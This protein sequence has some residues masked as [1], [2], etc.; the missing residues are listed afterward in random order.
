VTDEMK[1][2]M[3]MYAK[4]GSRDMW[5]VYKQFT[6]TQSG[7]SRQ[8]KHIKQSWVVQSAEQKDKGSS[9]FF[10]S[11][12]VSAKGFPHECPMGQWK[13]H[14]G[15]NNVRQPTMT[16]SLVTTITTA[17]LQSTTNSIVTPPKIPAFTLR[18]FQ[19]FASST[20]VV[21][22][23]LSSA[24]LA[25]QTAVKAGDF[26]QVRVVHADVG[27]DI[28]INLRDPNN[29]RTFLHWAAF[30]G[31][32]MV[33]IFLIAFGANADIEGLG[34]AT[35]LHLAAQEGRLEI[36]TLLLA[37]GVDKDKANTAGATAL[38]LAAR[39]G[40]VSVV[41]VWLM[42]HYCHLKP[43]VYTKHIPSRLNSVF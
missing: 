20:P 29:G 25:F 23:P 43:S 39:E 26:D 8:T 40:H 33:A 10:A 22:V 36:V 34:G 42:I 4:V 17:T 28:D 31:H 30:Y 6:I 14:D 11:C 24:H 9:K 18:E 5:L 37:K 1:N 19:G 15:S 13:V 3:P 41:K 35:P 7:K 38:S 32:A 2:S 21:T 27:K 16:V 12:E